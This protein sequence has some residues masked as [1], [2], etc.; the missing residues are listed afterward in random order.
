MHFPNLDFK[1]FNFQMPNT[2]DGW[3]MI[4]KRFEKETHFPH[5]LSALA[6][7]HVIMQNPF[8]AS[9]TFHN[10]KKT[11]SI[12]LMGMCEANYCFNSANIGAQGRISDGGV[13]NAC[14]LAE[15][16]V[17][18]T[19]NVPPDEPLAIGRECIPYVIVAD[20]AFALRKNLMIPHA[21][22]EAQGFN[23]V[24]RIFN[25]RLSRAR[26]RNENTFGILSSV[27]RVFQKPML[28]QPGKVR[29]TTECCVL[30]HNFLRKSRTSRASYTPAGTFDHYA[31]V[32]G[33]MQTIDGLW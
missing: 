18:G 27:F 8:H 32:D 14:S 13:C 25:Y 6:G 28:L 2:P 15:T 17:K 30:L 21:A 22:R 33:E 19:L 5:C 7:K 16:A 3:I 31:Q 12:V 9:S 10:Y 11:L 24:E 23:S 26:G 1:V 20:N 29:T 4:A